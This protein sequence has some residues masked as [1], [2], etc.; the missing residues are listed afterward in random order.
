MRMKCPKCG[1]IVSVA[2]EQAGEVVTCPQCQAKMRAPSPR[3]NEATPK[4][5]VPPPLRFSADDEDPATAQITAKPPKRP[6]APQVDELEIVEDED[7]DA[8]ELVEIPQFKT[9]PYKAVDGFSLAGVAVMIGVMAPIA[10]LLGF[11]ASAI[12]TVFYLILVF[13]IGI[14]FGV[15]FAG[16]FGGKLG[17]VHSPIMS[18]LA[19]LLGGILAVLVMHYFDNLWRLWAEQRMRPGVPPL[20][21]VTLLH[22]RAT[23]GI[24]LF[25]RPGQN[26]GLT[27]S[28]IGAYIYWFIEL[29]VITGISAAVMF[30]AGAEPFCTECN[31][32]KKK[33][34]VGIFRI[35]MRGKASQAEADAKAAFSEGNLTFFT[36]LPGKGENF[37]PLTV[38]ILECEECG[39]SVPVEVRL[40][41]ISIDGNGNPR[42]ANVATVTYPHKA[43]P[44]VEDL[45]H[46][47]EEA[48]I[49]RKKR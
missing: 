49:R 3:T 8:S 24:V 35:P 32:W 45:V 47:A 25:A 19:G 41:K 29:A 38:D 5:S 20:G 48:E 10:I 28:G 23:E 31:N 12:G 30:A 17:K 27:I 44:V 18:F 34:R 11:L 43:I 14:G 26:D 15:G 21:F 42:E 40:V 33:R 9:R 6:V 7:G 16:A 2:D 39:K 46:A 13:P 22:V 4:A 37:L 36:D 1:E